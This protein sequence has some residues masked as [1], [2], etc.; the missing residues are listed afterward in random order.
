MASFGSSVRRSSST[1]F[2]R[3]EAGVGA[4]LLRSGQVL[5][6]VALVDAALQKSCSI[7][8]MPYSSPDL[9]N[10][11]AGRLR[12]H[13]FI[14][15]I[16]RDPNHLRAAVQAGEGLL[17]CATVSGADA[18]WI[19]PPGYESLSGTA[20]LGYAHGA[21]G[22]ADTLLDLFEAT[23]EQRFL[24][25]AQRANHWLASLA[26]PALDDGK[27]LAW[28]VDL[29]GALFGPFW[30]HGAAGIG[31][32]LLHAAQVGVGH[33]CWE[34]AKRA[35]LTVSRGGRW[36]GPTQCHGLAGNIEFLIDMFQATG[37]PIY[38]SNAND[39]AGALEAFSLENDDELLWQSETPSIITPDY[40]VGYAG[41]AVCL[42]R[43]GHPETMPHQLSRRGFQWRCSSAKVEGNWR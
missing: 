36:A 14:W 33:E 11:T 20:N 22:I 3:R 18:C 34:L 16:T 12:F 8:A 10:G 32:F 9:Y 41:I 30:C 28:P 35:A 40:L 1:W 43:L 37:D 24:E 19:I 5:G 38:L 26:I 39:L 42:L 29:E 2:I 17:Q 31:R 7:A 21:A 4:A 13:L 23:G 25:V 6:D 15:D 27:G